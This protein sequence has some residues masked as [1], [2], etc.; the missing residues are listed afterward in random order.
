MI[1]T[2]ESVRLSL[3]YDEWG[4]HAGLLHP[5]DKQR[6]DGET[7]NG[8]YGNTGVPRA[9]GEAVCKCGFIFYLHPPVQGA[10]YFTRTCEGIVKL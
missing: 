6:I 5:D 2:P 10:L 3:G 7:P 1:G 9:G 8:R 4:N